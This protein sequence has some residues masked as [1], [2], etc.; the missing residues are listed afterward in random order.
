MV[1]NLRV[2]VTWK[3]EKGERGKEGE[4]QGHGME[5]GKM[6]EREKQYFSGRKG[7]RHPNILAARE[8]DIELPNLCTKTFSEE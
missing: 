1:A 2:A 8:Q 6:G 4:R 3:E 5:G 7:P